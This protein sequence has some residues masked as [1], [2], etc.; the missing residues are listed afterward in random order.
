MVERKGDLD[1]RTL[2]AILAGI[3]RALPFAAAGQCI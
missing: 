2:T 3:N 1:N